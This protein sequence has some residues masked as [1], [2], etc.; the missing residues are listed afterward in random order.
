MAC[1]WG[2]LPGCG[3]GEVQIG[4]SAVL[5]GRSADVSLVL[6]ILLRPLAPQCLQWILK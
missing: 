4:L 6:E 3:R 2:K 5:G 1:R